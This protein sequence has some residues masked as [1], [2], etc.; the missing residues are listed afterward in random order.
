MN[1]VK[2]P[3][4]IALDDKSAL[5]WLYFFQSLMDRLDYHSNILLSF[6]N[7]DEKHLPLVPPKKLEEMKRRLVT[8]PPHSR[9]L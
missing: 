2:A 1:G 4:V 7:K 6:E 9:W 8:L 5:C 3:S